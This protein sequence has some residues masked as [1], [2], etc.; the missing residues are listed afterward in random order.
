[1]ERKEQ[2][3][4]NFSTDT[5]AVGKSFMR[6]MVKLFEDFNGKNSKTSQTH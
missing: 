1:M 5:H 6:V 4:M 3:Q 2:K